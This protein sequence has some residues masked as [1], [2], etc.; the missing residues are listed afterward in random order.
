MT[1]P[2]IYEMG[3]RQKVFAKTLIYKHDLTNKNANGII[4]LLQYFLCLDK[5]VQNFVGRVCP[6]YKKIN[7]WL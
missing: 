1:S 5:D 6:S 3:H 4:T 2:S 7:I